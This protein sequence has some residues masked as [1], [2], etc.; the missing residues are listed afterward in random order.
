MI[1]YHCANQKIAENSDSKL[2]AIRN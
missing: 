1:L 2:K